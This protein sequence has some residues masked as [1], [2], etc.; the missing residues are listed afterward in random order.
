MLYTN[1]ND[2]GEEFRIPLN[3]IFEEKSI[4]VICV[5]SSVLD[6]TRKVKLNIL[7]R[8]TK[9][10]LAAIEFGSRGKELKTAINYL[11]TIKEAKIKFIACSIV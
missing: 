5:T 10:P 3:F 11:L 2:N 4:S 1:Q 6:E 8:S 9:M 7:Y